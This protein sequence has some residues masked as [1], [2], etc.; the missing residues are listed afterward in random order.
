M[1]IVVTGIRPMTATDVAGVAG[2]EAANQPRPWSETVFAEELA[3][4]DRAYF[5]VEGAE[6]ILGFAGVMVS[7][8]EAHVMNLLVAPDHRG[9]GLARRLMLAV[10][11]A[12]RDRGARS[13]TLEVRTGNV[14]ARGLYEDFGLAPVGTRPG[15]Y[16]D[17]DALILWAHDI[18]GPEYAARLDRL[19]E[20]GSDG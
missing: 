7:G 16:G 11:D 14:A 12:A 15:Y 17:E 9:R 5:V 4:D 6:G 8:E 18:D 3:R 10:V 2:L 13:L 20:N 1:G 19:R